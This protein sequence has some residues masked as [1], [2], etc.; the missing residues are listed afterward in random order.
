MDVIPIFSECNHTQDAY[1]TLEQEKLIIHNC[2]NLPPEIIFLDAM[3]SGGDFREYL[4]E[5]KR[6]NRPICL[7]L[8]P[9]IACFTLPSP[10][11]IYRELHTMPTNQGCYSK[12]LMCYF[13]YSAEDTTVTLVDDEH[14]LWMKMQ[15]ADD[16]GIPYCVAPYALKE[17]MKTP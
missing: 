15:A 14:T 10:D 3:I 8:L 11:G 5:A 13:S 4:M 6:E 2:S 1:C 7:I 17:K 9:K 16:A 12:A